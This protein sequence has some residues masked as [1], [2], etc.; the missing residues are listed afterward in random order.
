M[1]NDI[2]NAANL[3]AE[4]VKK[5]QQRREQWL[6]KHIELKSH[7]TEIADY[8]NTNA[9]YKQGFFVDTLHAFDEDI[10]GTSAAM[11]SVTLRSGD[12]PMLVTFHSIMGE[13]KEYI[14]EGFQITFT[15]TITGEVIVLFMPHQN[16]LNKKEQQYTTLEVIN[17]PAM[18]SMDMADGII[19]KGIEQAFYSSFTG[20]SEAEGA[21]QRTPIGFKL[22]ETTEKVK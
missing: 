20:I 16:E 21:P 3:Y 17:E 10:N 7:L 13:K 18:L 12:M 4:G 11:P 9:A 22:H 1:L 5:V 6:Q 15:P 2:L 14:E 8:L 19:A